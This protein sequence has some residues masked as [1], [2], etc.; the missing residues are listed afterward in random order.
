MIK[1]SF[2][3]PTSL[4]DKYGS[5]GDFHLTLAHLLKGDEE[6]KYEKAI[7]QSGLPIYLDN[8]LFENGVS[9][10][11]EDLMDHAARLNAEYVFAPDVLYNREET[12]K[13]IDRAYDELQEANER[14]GS[15]TKLAAVVQADNEEDYL[16]S[17]MVFNDDSRISLIGL[18]ILSIPKSFEKTIGRYSISGSRKVCMEK[19][20]D[21][22]F[23][24]KK[25]HLLGAGHTYEDIIEANQ[26][27][28][29]D[30]HDSS[31]AIW[32]GVQGHR[33]FSNGWIHGGKTK[34][35]VDFDFN[36][37]IPEK[38]LETIDFNIKNVFKFTNHE[39]N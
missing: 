15:S 3:S 18:S 35:P 10:P 28:W 38:R 6:T 12:E 32:N 13:N 9:V 4:I 25:C 22:P 27:D 30:S 14:Y 34:V 37:R 1:V 8:G 19:I 29:I 31:S 24:K 39:S 16:R 20:D 36:E 26:Y 5:K 11:V 23:T 33:I 17:F 21:L 2:I 7:K